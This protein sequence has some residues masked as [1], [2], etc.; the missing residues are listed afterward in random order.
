M[1]EKEIEELF[2]LSMRAVNET[3]C[4]VRYSVAA[5]TS[6]IYVDVSD[7]SCDEAYYGDGTK[8]GN[9]DQYVIYFDGVLAEY[10]REQYISAKNHL[11]RLLVNGKCPLNLEE[12][13]A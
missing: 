10:S 11:L 5:H 13:S 9:I 6:A 1:F 12:E 2:K 4:F 7:K 8:K 3:N